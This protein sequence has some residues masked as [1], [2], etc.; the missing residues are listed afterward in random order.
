M[1]VFAAVTLAVMVMASANVTPSSAA[2]MS[3]PMPGWTRTA[4][5]R[6]NQTIRWNPAPRRDSR[7]DSRSKTA[8]NLSSSS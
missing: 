6:K 4:A 2:A 5:I 7:F 8:L 3:T 1:M